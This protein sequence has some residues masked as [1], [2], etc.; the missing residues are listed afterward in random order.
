MSPVVR[1][2]SPPPLIAN[3]ALRAAIY[4]GLGLYLI[5][6]FSTMDVNWTRMAEGVARA[7]AHSQAAQRPPLP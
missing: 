6:A 7:S 1:R 3:P 2:W 4:I 5:T